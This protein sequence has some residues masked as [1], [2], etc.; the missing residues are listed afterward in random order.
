MKKRKA[1]TLVEL[2]VV[3]A[4]IALLIAILAPSLKAAKDLAKATYCMANQNALV[5]S[6]LVYAEGNRGFMPVYQHKFTVG[7]INAPDNTYKSY[8]CFN[9][10]T[11]DPKTLLFSDARGLGLVYAAGLL[12]PPDLF[13]CPDQKDERMTLANYPKPWGTAVG[14]ESGF[15]RMGY[16]WDPWV[17]QN[18]SDSAKWTYEDALMAGRHPTA[19]FLTAD[20]LD[21]YADVSHT[22]SNSARWNLAYADSHVEPFENKTLYNE[23]FPGTGMGLDASQDW[24]LFNKDPGGVRPFLPG[25]KIQQ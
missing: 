3:I 23:F 24:L 25:N 21:D 7:I 12:G 19:R 6:A 2:L 10:S 4:I 13:Y 20:L 14:P 15:V 22:T 11:P 17:M 16:M 8:V 9:T 1:F 18:P 5:K